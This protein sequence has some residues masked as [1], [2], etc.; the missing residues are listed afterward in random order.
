LASV[1]YSMRLRASKRTS[2]AMR[3]CRSCS[4]PSIVALH[5]S[6]LSCDMEGLPA[7]PA[8][9]WAEGRQFNGAPFLATVSAE[10][11]Q[12]HGRPSPCKG[13]HN[14]IGTEGQFVSLPRR[15]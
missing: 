3:F 14:R 13:Y 9:A 2:P 1:L 11:A 15:F 5:L 6:P 4:R 12:L 8:T 7:P 10:G